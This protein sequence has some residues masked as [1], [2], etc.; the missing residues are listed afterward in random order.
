MAITKQINITAHDGK[1]SELHA[2]LT[3][4][5]RLSAEESGCLY[6]FAWQQ[7]SE[8]N[9]II[10][11]SWVDQDSLDAHKKTAH[12]LEFKE[13]LSLLVKDKSSENLTFM[14]GTSLDK[15]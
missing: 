10:I 4:V 6:Y 2:M 12:F 7:S 15:S 13:N 14:A 3:N 9:F 11:E 1:A 8:D 5:A